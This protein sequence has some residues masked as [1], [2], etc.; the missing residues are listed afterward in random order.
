MDFYRDKSSSHKTLRPGLSWYLLSLPILTLFF[1]P[2]LALVIHTSPASLFENLKA[3]AVLSAM[4]ISLKT[5]LISTLLTL[6]LGTPLAFVLARGAFPFRRLLNSLVDLPIVL[7]PAVAGVA[8]LIAFGR[9]GLLGTPLSILGLEIPFTQLAV[10]LAQMFVAAPLFIR[11]AI[12][13]LNTI[14]P[15]IENAAVLDGASRWQTLR[16]ITL[17]LTRKSL[18]G[19]AVLTWARALGEFGATLIFA[20]NLAGRTQTMPLA[21]F[22]GF[23]INLDQAITLSVLLMAISFSVLVVGRF[24][25]DR[26][27]G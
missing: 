13:S 2:L 15:D 16:Y 18:M 20:G 26:E 7:P 4:G 24:L 11:I 25:L 14:D 12:N 19:G 27:L 6:L 5:S 9:Q 17:P 21:I 1:L 3:P 23:E 22:I 10:T 8:L